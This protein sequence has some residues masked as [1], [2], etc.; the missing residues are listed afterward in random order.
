MAYRGTIKLLTLF[1]IAIVYISYYNEFTVIIHNI[2]IV[3]F[4]GGLMHLQ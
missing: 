3:C 2:R 4:N 1:F